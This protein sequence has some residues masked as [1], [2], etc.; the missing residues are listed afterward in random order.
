MVIR[1]T[2]LVRI[3]EI[4]QWFTVLVLSVKGLFIFGRT[5]VFS[6]HSPLTSIAMEIHIGSSCRLVC[7]WKVSVVIV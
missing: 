3:F 4:L 2:T 1:I 6:E 5:F 7:S